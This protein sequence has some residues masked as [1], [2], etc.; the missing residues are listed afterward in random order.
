MLKVSG[1]STQEKRRMN[2]SLI[3]RLER[4]AETL[5]AKLT[6]IWEKDPTVMASFEACFDTLLD[7]VEEGRVYSA[8]APSVLNAIYDDL[9]PYENEES[10]KSVNL[11]AKGARPVPGHGQF[12]KLL[13]PGVWVAADYA[14]YRTGSNPKVWTTYSRGSRSQ[15]YIPDREEVARRRANTEATLGP[16]PIKGLSPHLHAELIAARAIKMGH[17]V[18]A[19]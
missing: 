4:R 8:H 13:R 5:R 9:L 15:A 1:M 11:P 6:R 16:I 3:E 12:Y 7:D 14:Q 2:Y 10:R 19:A 18:T 17:Q